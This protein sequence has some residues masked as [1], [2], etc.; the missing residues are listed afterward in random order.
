MAVV[1]L[2]DGVF[3]AQ[4][5]MVVAALGLVATLIAPMAASRSLREAR[6]GPELRGPGS[7][8]SGRSGT[9]TGS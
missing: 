6:A 3:S 1:L 4:M 7:E 9:R 8:P 2:A 5:F